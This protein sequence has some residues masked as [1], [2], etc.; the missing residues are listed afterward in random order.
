MNHLDDHLLEDGDHCYYLVV[1]P[2]DRDLALSLDH[3]SGGGDDA[4]PRTYDHLGDRDALG[5]LACGGDH[6]SEMLVEVE[7]Y[8][9]RGSHSPFLDHEP[10]RLLNRLQIRYLLQILRARGSKLTS[11]S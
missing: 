10:H 11:S 5:A 9:A 1:L 3:R 7:E 8:Q 4:C 6:S 2:R